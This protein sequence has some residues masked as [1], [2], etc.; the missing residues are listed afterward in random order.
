VDY[1]YAT[2]L[3]LSFWHVTDGAWHQDSISANDYNAVD[4]WKGVSVTERYLV[5]GS[6]GSYNP[7]PT[8]SGGQILLTAQSR[9]WQNGVWQIKTMEAAWGN[10]TSKKYYLTRAAKYETWGDFIGRIVYAP[11]PSSMNWTSLAAAGAANLWNYQD[12]D[13]Q[14][15]RGDLVFSPERP[16]LL[17]REKLWHVNNFTGVVRSVDLYS[18]YSAGS[19][20]TPQDSDGAR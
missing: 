6:D 8:G 1:A 12:V 20:F 9:R 17:F 11:Q 4:L 16:I 19:G 13:M 15:G 2:E 10:S 5:V 7:N 18:A 14:Y 3:A